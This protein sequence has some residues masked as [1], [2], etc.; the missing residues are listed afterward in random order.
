LYACE[1]KWKFSLCYYTDAQRTKV[2]YKHTFGRELKEGI[3]V[4][5][6]RYDH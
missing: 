6:L 5:C 2:L 4:I 3:L 1:R